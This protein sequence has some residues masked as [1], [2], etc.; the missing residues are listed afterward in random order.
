M[1]LYYYLIHSLTQHKTSTVYR[2]DTVPTVNCIKDFALVIVTIL[3]FTERYLCR[4][5]CDKKNW[6]TVAL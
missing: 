6:E 4:Q 5:H 2:A 3:Y 1:F